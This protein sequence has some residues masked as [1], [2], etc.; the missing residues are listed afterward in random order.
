MTIARCRRAATSTRQTPRINWCSNWRSTQAPEMK[1]FLFLAM[2]LL[3]PAPGFAQNATTQVNGAILNG[4]PTTI[5]TP[6]VPNGDGT[7]SQRAVPFAPP[8]SHNFPGCTVATSSGTCLA[9]NTAVT[10]LQ[11]QNTSATA[12]V[13]C[14]FGTTAVLNATNSFQLA[15]GQSASWGPST[16]GVPTGALNCI[17]S[18]AST[19]LYVEWN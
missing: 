19:P 3:S 5:L 12:S 14:A 9:A 4:T 18:A 11:V 10:F 1:K 16:G 17:A 7:Y 8:A 2:A 6:W 13:A 15:P